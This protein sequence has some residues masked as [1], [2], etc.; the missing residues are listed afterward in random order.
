MKSIIPSTYS[1]WRALWQ[2][3]FITPKGIFYWGESIFREGVTLMA[4]LR[5]SAK[6][7]PNQLALVSNDEKITY[8]SLY[9]SAQSLTYLLYRHYGLRRGMRV[10]LLCRN[11]ALVP[12]ILAALSR[13]GVAA[14]LLNTDMGAEKL[15]QLLA[16]KH[17]YD[18]FII[19]SSLMEGFELSLKGE[20]VVYSE[21][22][23]QELQD[24]ALT[25][26][27]SLP[28]IWRGAEMTV[29]SGGSSGH[30]HEA[31]RR[32][33]A[34]QFLPPLVA[35]LRQIGIHRYKSVYIALPLYHGFGL[36]TLIT[37][38]VMGKMV[39]LTRRFYTEEAL[40]T[41]EKYQ[42]QVMPL[43]PVMLAR[44]LQEDGASEQLRSLRCI[45]SG[46]DRLERKLVTDTER[47]LGKVLYNLYGTS[48]AGFFLLATPVDLA[49]N[50]QTTLGKP[51]AG[52]YCR[53]ER[54]D[55]Q[56]IGTLWVRSRWAMNGRR[57]RWQSTGDRMCRNKFG[58][59]FHEGRVD[60]MIVSGGENLYPD[61]VERT[62]AAH[63]AVLTVQV[64]PIPHPQWG[65]VLEALV[66]L[67]PNHSLSE[68]NLREWLR[69]RI[70]RHEMPHR[71]YFGKVHLLETGK[72]RWER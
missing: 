14:H 47:L 64:R 17:R 8:S 50:K 7:Y 61:V 63:P 4:L 41:I 68:K 51:I 10:A 16:S 24:S 71:I 55:D 22:L 2:L 13:L 62:I 18:L 23:S 29:L 34:V 56:G 9:R 3:R 27:I 49:N 39:V 70:A 43:V 59:Y 60:S 48:E 42:V 30:Y 57:N 5:F 67:H 15:G 19:D 72:R 45:L 66:E 58:Y 32:P 20:R 1:L 33:S 31:A 12:F 35:L 69:P 44:L 53:I 40:H 46:G 37:S 52:V 11:H 25:A 38:L 6:S 26:S 54:P 21:Q 36:A 28:Y 65:Q